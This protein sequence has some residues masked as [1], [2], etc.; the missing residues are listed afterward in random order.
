[1]IPVTAYGI[2]K[3]HPNKI[4]ASPTTIVIRP[5]NESAMMKAGH[6]PPQ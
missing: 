2:P 1:V 4:A 6:P 3:A 5:M